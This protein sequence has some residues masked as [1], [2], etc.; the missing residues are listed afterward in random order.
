MIS[1]VWISLTREEIAWEDEDGITEFD[2]VT[3]RDR[4]VGGPQPHWTEVHLPD[5]RR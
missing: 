5:D 3:Q 4:T 2:T 1:R